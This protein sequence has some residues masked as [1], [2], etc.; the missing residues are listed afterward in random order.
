MLQIER[1]E[2]ILGLLAT[3]TAHRVSELAAALYTSEATVRRDLTAMEKEGLVRRVYGGVVLAREDPPLD[4][5]RQENAAAK[6]DIARRAA[7]LIRDGDTVF[8]DASSTVLHI[9]PHLS[10][11]KDL[12]VVTNSHRAVELLA[13]GNHRVFCTGGQLLRRNLAY[14]GPL[15]EEMLRSLSFDIAFFSSRGVSEEGEITDSS[16]EETW[17]RRV[18]LSRA[19]RKVF[20]ADASKRGQRYLF[21]LGHLEDMDEVIS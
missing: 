7:A 4:F 3:A 13:G 11:L 17:L 8:L 9:L 5:R 6:A 16:E 18:A 20:L 12:T 1:K 2:R 10:R 21:L 19:A 15:A 14:V